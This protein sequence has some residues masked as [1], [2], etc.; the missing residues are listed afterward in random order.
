VLGDA[1]GAAGL[2]GASS[3][4]D[5]EGAFRPTGDL[6]PAGEEGAV[7]GAALVSFV[8]ALTTSGREAG[9]C[10]MVGTSISALVALEET[11]AAA[12]GE[13]P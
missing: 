12:C 3:D 13:M 1:E 4:A 11:G 6:G 5:A 9:A 7:G 8:R 2:T 10:L